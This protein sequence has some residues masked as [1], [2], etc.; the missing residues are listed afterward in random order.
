MR[1][2]IKNSESFSS[3]FEYI[4]IE[5]LH[6]PVT[7]ITTDSRELVDGDLYVALKGENFD[8]H[9]FLKEVS[10]RG[11]S[12]ALVSEQDSELN[13]QQILVE[14]TIDIIAVFGKGREDYQIVNNKKLY[15][16]DLK[17]IEEYIWG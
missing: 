10:K 3:T 12:A 8:G 9:S 7:G 1:I 5:R 6:H 13:F 2:A 16:S 11:A 15:H 14:D 4:T 17:I